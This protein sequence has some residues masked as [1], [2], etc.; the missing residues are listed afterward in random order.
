MSSPTN[1]K[2]CQRGLVGL[3]EIS[4]GLCL[5]CIAKLPAEI[6][7]LQED[8]G[9]LQAQGLEAATRLFEIGNMYN[10][11][12]ALDGAEKAG[13]QAALRGFELD[14]NPYKDEEAR[15]MWEHGHQ[16]ASI[17]KQLAENQSLVAWALTELPLILELA[18]TLG[19]KEVAEK[20]DAVIQK[21]TPV[22]AELLQS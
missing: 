12:L 15:L 10:R 2:D 22:V 1:C 3:A 17:G 16:T 21:L 9:R 14:Q 6:K 5:D 18:E 13:E 8:R 4:L 11:R 19:P 7:A 20:L